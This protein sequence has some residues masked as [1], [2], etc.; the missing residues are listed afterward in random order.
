MNRRLLVLPALTLT[1][2]ASGAGLGYSVG[3]ADAPAPV[4]VAREPLA[5]TTQVRGAADRTLGLT[6]VTVM[7]GAKLASHHHPG[8]QIARIA[9][10]TLTYTVETGRV[11]VM[12]GDAEDA[13]FVRTI[14]AG[15][16]GQVRTGQWIV[17]QPNEVH[18]AANRGTE[19]V[20][21]YLATLFPDGAPA[22]VAD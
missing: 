3:A 22:S 18:H 19:P 5:A 11:R 21:I 9:N 7:P 2:L 16:T 12:R 17:E 8:T 4:S 15:Q 13:T 1:L 20:V 14:K 6:R 10:G